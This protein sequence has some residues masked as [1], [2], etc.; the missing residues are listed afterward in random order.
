[1]N[2]A[3]RS[4]PGLS[5]LSPLWSVPGVSFVSLQKGQGEEEALNPPSN[6]P[7]VHFGS[8]IE[9]FADTAAIVEQLDL[10]ICVDTSIAHLAGALN[11]PCWVMLPGVRTDW[12]W[13]RDRED[14]PWYPGIRLFR[15]REA[16]NWDEVVERVRKAL[17]AVMSDRARENA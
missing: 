3:N 2:D 11:K 8:D 16:G 9:D 12:R 5:I 1:M 15:Q 7:L 6:Q 4:L 14:S 17:I 10:V 13:M